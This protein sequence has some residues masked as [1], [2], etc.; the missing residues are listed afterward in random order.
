MSAI[1]EKYI[2]DV[3]KDFRERTGVILCILF[4]ED[5]SILALDCDIPEN[6]YEKHQLI[7]VISSEILSLSND[8]VSLLNKNLKIT[9]ISIQAGDSKDMESFTIILQTII[10]EIMILILAPNRLNFGVL[11]YEI[12]ELLSE[13]KKYLQNLTLKEL[14]ELKPMNYED[15]FDSL[16]KLYIIDNSGIPLYNYSFTENNQNEE[17]DSVLI[18]GGV[19]GLITI[20]K[21]ITHGNKEIKKIDHGDRKVIFKKTSMGNIIFVLIVKEEYLIFH[22]MLNDLVN[23][24]EKEYKNLIEDIEKNNFIQENWQ[25]LGSLIKNIFYLS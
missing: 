18:S 14:L 22:K 4:T 8:G 24:F 25:N 5:G 16:L 21:E 17:D 10:N 11:L 20:L 7:S 15:Y 13:L 9:Q 19:I 1:G 6:D 2:L 3:L 23:H 12:N